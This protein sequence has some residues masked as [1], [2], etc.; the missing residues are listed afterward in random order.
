MNF[1]QYEYKI[2]G[3]PVPI[4]SLEKLPLQ[5][6]GPHPQNFGMDESEAELSYGPADGVEGVEEELRPGPE[7]RVNDDYQVRTVILPT[8]L[9]CIKQVQL[10]QTRFYSE[11]PSDD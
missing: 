6:V 11:L 5:E 8:L 10:F 4:Y 2:L 1:N 7:G 9:N 3:H